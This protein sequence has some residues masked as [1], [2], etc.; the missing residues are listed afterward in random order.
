MLV[1]RNRIPN[2]VMANIF[3]RFTYE[4]DDDDKSIKQK[5]EQSTDTLVIEAT[6][7]SW[8]YIQFPNEQ[9]YTL[10]LLKWS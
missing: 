10:F 1:D 3:Q 6:D 2:D 9:A 7:N 4:A 8:M 5:F